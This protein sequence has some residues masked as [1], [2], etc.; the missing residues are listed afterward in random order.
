VAF[1]Y[2]IST[3][4][5]KVTWLGSPQPSLSLI[6]LPL[7]NDFSRFQCSVFIQI[8]KLHRP[9]SP[10]FTPSRSSLPLTGPILPSC[11]SLFKCIFHHGISPVNVLYFS[12]PLP[13]SLHLFVLTCMVQQLSVYSTV[14]FPQTGRISTQCISVLLLSSPSSRSPLKQ[15]HYCKHALCVYDHVCV[16][17]LLEILLFTPPV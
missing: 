15:S 3:Y 11:P 17:Y 6:P 16:V 9:Y 1:C 8:Y 5:Y 13:F 12:H 10:S 2:D 7:L 14:L 4:V